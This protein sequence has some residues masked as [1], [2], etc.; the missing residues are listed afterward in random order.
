MDKVYISNLIVSGIHGVMAV[1]QRRK[2]GFRVDVVM[3]VD[4]NS[5]AA[6]DELNDA[7]DYKVVRD[8][9]QAII[10]GPSQHLL[11]RLAQMMIDAIHEDSRVQKTNLSIRKLEIWENGQP[12]V[13]LTRENKK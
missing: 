9:I 12:G 11:E 2:Q 13:E 1:E 10:D 5:A 8:K 4:C 3:D 6:S 7:V